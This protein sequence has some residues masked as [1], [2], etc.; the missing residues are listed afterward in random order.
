M[1][2]DSIQSHAIKTS[3]NGMSLLNG[4]MYPCD[5]RVAC[6]NQPEIVPPWIRGWLMIRCSS[7]SRYSF[8]TCIHIHKPKP[9]E[10]YNLVIVLGEFSM[11]PGF[12]LILAVSFSLVSL[13]CSQLPTM[14]ACGCVPFLV[15]R[16]W[17]RSNCQTWDWISFYLLGKIPHLS[18]WF[19]DMFPAKIMVS[20]FNFSG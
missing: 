18:I 16:E 12:V 15:Q 3:N 11:V 4:H 7:T 17:H 9:Q 19:P 14:D 20:H 10:T 8:C 13:H 6:T 2:R 5:S 1:S